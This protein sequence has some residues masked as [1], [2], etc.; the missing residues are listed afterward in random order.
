METP[1][2]IK[3][4]TFETSALFE[5]WQ[6]ESLAEGIKIDIIN[7]IPVL[8]NTITEVART[9]DRRMDMDIEMNIFVVY[10]Q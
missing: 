3:C 1:K 5:S 10:I 6:T 7:V 2:I 8:S 9:N 4:R